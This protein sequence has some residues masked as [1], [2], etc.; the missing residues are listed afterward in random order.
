MRRTHEQ[1]QLAA[2]RASGGRAS[3][4]RWPSARSP[5]VRRR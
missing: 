2:P 3:P 4:P 5:P 1:E